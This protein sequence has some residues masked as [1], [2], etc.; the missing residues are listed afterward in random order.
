[1]PPKVNPKTLKAVRLV[2]EGAT[3]AEAISKSKCLCTRKNLEAHVKRVRARSQ[4]V[5][6]PPTFCFN[7]S[8][9][10]AAAAAAAA[11]VRLRPYQKNA[12]DRGN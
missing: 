9:A 5:A 7:A 3:M 10:A 1:M 2:L 6:A 11:S 8:A 4:A 12:V